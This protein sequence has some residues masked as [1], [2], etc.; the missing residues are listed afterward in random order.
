MAII[1]NLSGLAAALIC[2]YGAYRLDHSYQQ[3]RTKILR[4]Y[5][6][7]FFCVG[8]AFFILALPGIVLFDPF[9]IQ[10]DFILVDISFLMAILFFGPAIF[11]ISERLHRFKK[12]IFFLILFWILM[13]I[14]LNLI[15]FSKALPLIE[16]NLVYFWKSGTLWL[17]SIARGFTVASSLLLSI[18]FFRWI[19]I[20][21]EKKV[22]YRSFFIGLSFLL[23]LIAGSIFWFSPFFY[24]SLNLL[25][26]TGFL[27]L[28]GV[29]AAI[30]GVLLF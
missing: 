8:S 29:T 1:F 22:I 25:I 5:S 28:L 7:G 2:F 9:W 30:I 15:F 27:G 20:S 16:N 12:K 14:F 26:F 17:Q 10:I 19:K 23:V 4:A 21:I 3:I 6:N 24:F 11:S 13:Y 18:L